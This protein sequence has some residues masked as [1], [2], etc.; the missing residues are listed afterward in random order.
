MISACRL[1]GFKMTISKL[2]VFVEAD[3][4]D[5][6]EGT[7]LVKLEGKPRP[8]E[9]CVRNETGVVDV[10]IRP[11]FEAWSAKVKIRW[12]ADIFSDTDVANLLM[13]AGMQVG[14]LEGRP[15]SKGS[16]GMGWFAFAK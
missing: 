7:P 11:M 3:G 2:S 1:V 9:M 8:L 15:D 12:D 10:R 4:F 14:I 16:A 13:R 6:D 5:A